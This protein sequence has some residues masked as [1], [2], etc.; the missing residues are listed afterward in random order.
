M[1]RTGKPAATV[2]AGRR[3]VAAQRRGGILA[4]TGRVS[5]TVLKALLPLVLLVAIGGGIAYFRLSNGPVSLSLLSEPIARSITAELDGLTAAIDDTEVAI[6]RRGLEVRLIGLKLIDAERRPVAVA[7]IATIDLSAQA[8][9][10]G[11]LAPRH[12][13]LIEPRMLL[14]ISDDGRVAL[15]VSDPARGDARV[16]PPS[17]TT[18][19]KPAAGGMRPAAGSP[20]PATQADSEPNAGN[21]L[22][23]LDIARA[24]VDAARRAR[25]NTDTA[26]FLR[27]I[28]VRDAGLILDS[29]GR[30]TAWRLPSASIS[31]RHSEESSRVTADASIISAGH[32]WSLALEAV[33]DTA[34]DAV[35]LTVN[36][37][38]LVPGTLAQLHPAWTLLEGLKLP[39]GISSNV[40]LSRMGDVS[41]WRAL[42]ALGQGDVGFAAMSGLRAGM[43]GGTLDLRYDRQR[44]QI[45]LMPSTLSWA[46]G[47]LTFA[48]AMA[49]ASSAPG[50]QRWLFEVGSIDGELAT[51]ARDKPLH[52]EQLRIAGEIQGAAGRVD[53]TSGVL[54]VGD[55]VIDAG[56]WVGGSGA[57]LADRV[58]LEGRIGRMSRPTM[59]ALW[60]RGLSPALYDWVAREVEAVEIAGG[61]F[62]IG[63]GA[64]G[65]VASGGGEAELSAMLSLEIGRA[66]FRPAPGLP[67]V[68]VTRALYRLEGTGFEIAIPEGRIDLGQGRSIAVS[69]ARIATA[70]WWSPAAEADVTFRLQ[71][72]L[73]EAVALIEQ[74]LLG[75][76][77]VPLLAGASVLGTAEGQFRTRVAL[78][79]ATGNRTAYPIEGTARITDG[80]LRN[81]SGIGDIRG[82]GVSFDLNDKAI[83]ATGSMLVSG[84]PAKLTWQRILSGGGGDQPPLRIT[85]TLDDADRRQLGVDLSH[86]LHG[87]IG[88]EATVPMPRAGEPKARVRIDLSPAELFIQS[89][90]WTK[91]PGRGASLQFD[92]VDVEKPVRYRTELKNLSLVGDGIAITGSAM[93]DGKG[94]IRQFD[95]PQFS[96]NT[97]SRLGLKGELGR[98]NVWKVTAAGPTYDGQDIFRS[99]FQIT[100]T[101]EP[102]SYVTKNA[103]GLDLDARVT[104]VIGFSDTS[105]RGVTLKLSR[106]GG[107]L[108]S[109]LARGTLDGGKIL[110][111]GLQS[112]S[113][114]PRRMVALSDD[115]GQTFRLVGFYPNM[116]GGRMRLDANLDVRGRSE[117]TGL[118]Q[119]ENFQILGDPVL[120]E[121]VE[122]Y[123]NAE[124]AVVRRRV[125]ERTVARQTLLF[126]R[127]RAPFSVGNGQFVLREAELRGPLLG[128]SLTGKVDY[129]RSSVDISG[130]YVPLQALNAALAAIPG[131]G[132]LLTGPRGD[133]VW[134][135]NFAIQGPMAGPEVIVHPLS[136]VAPGIFRDLFQIQGGAARVTSP[137]RGDRPSTIAPRSSASEPARR[138]DGGGRSRTPEITGGWTSETQRP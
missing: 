31:L 101:E 75:V 30:R 118:L 132:Q 62:R 17:T 104:N 40:L 70:D 120:G 8:L 97:V 94:Q 25:L 1:P 126:D 24:L 53:V 59:E 57:R 83:S 122:S 68:D 84:V 106:R 38:D 95:L 78:Y 73:A 128:A 43:S 29:N 72:G 13:V 14:S 50:E 41:S 134:A 133:G 105:W 32:T 103:P 39:V 82:L 123:S 47:R 109:L 115:A 137:P 81:V 12:V 92:M 51:A 98:D 3:A 66:R 46:G 42:V 111:V 116:Q 65:Q 19:E 102:Q 136:L 113:N 85:A 77:R 35:R 69:S 28:G 27:T 48:G 37:R 93:L 56:G 9:L 5:L 124:G 60:P 76:G 55:T 54:K 129:L 90:A 79:A 130:T 67:P 135:M 91:P 63:G 36:L 11:R 131:L 87:E 6:G 99:L 34:V 127:M 44:G 20:V 110:E 71:G 15:T 86:V 138:R 114:A 107:R 64:T 89:L 21:D 49:P 125:G 58:H 74:P 26:S 33:D 23:R 108:T 18:R 22:G 96:I 52:I 80:R 4:A 45:D 16:P 117:R 121:V 88:V 7:P 112:T 10:Q 119:V 100:G 2:I 61:T